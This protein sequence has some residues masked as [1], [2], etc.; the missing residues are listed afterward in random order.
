[1]AAVKPAV[2]VPL[3]A[4]LATVS[5]TPPAKVMFAEVCASIRLK[6]LIDTASVTVTLVALEM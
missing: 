4:M 1:M 3:G 2:A 5:P 6:L